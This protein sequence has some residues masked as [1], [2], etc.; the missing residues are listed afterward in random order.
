MMGKANDLLPFKGQPDHIMVEQY[1][2]D[3]FTRLY[4][5]NGKPLD[6]G[7]FITRKNTETRKFELEYR[8]NVETGKRHR[9]EHD[10]QIFND[11]KSLVEYINFKL[12]MLWKDGF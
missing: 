4:F 10:T 9:E 11:S 12:G 3:D 8:T 7:I 1:T 5:Y 6:F 2:G